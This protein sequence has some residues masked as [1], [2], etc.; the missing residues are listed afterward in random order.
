MLKVTIIGVDLAKNVF[1]LR[2]A[3]ADR[4]AVLRKK[5]TR[6]LYERFMAGHHPCTVAMEASAGAHHWA[7]K[8]TRCGC[9]VLL[10]GL[11]YVKPFLKRQKHDAADAEAIVEAALR[12]T[13]R[14]F[15]TKTAEQRAQ[16]VAFRM[17]GQHL[18]QRTN[19]INVLRG[20]LYEFGFI[21]PE[22]FAHVPD[23][24]KIVKHR[25]SDLPD[26][27]SDLCKKVLTH[28]AELTEHL[29]DLG[30]KI[31]AVSQTSSMPRQLQ[32][33]QGIGPIG[34]L[35]IETVAPPMHLFRR[36]RDFAAWSGLFPGSIPRSGSSDSGRPPRMVS[37]TFDGY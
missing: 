36:A 12:P 19:S 13:M 8:F 2:G 18:K 33:I 31:A 21:A 4:T 14:F 26:I 28:M 5:L 7:R 16:A 1:Q 23:L 34:A 37:V 9:Q 24:A 11:H 6:L 20:Y 15:E 27:V 10:I 32:K 3:T 22:G 25:R 29:A 17:R 35:A 30:A